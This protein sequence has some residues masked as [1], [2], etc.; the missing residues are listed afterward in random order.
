VDVHFPLPTNFVRG[1]VTGRL[2][3]GVKGRKEEERSAACRQRRK[4][5]KK[6]RLIRGCLRA[7]RETKTKGQ[8]S[9]RSLLRERKKKLTLAVF[10]GRFEDLERAQKRIVHAHHR[11]RVVELSTAET[12]K[13]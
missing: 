8:V 3:V 2:A 1:G 9:E 12:E 13:K 7:K 6:T 4:R 11:S 10:T 5:G